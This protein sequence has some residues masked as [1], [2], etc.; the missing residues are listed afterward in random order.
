VPRC[1]QAGFSCIDDTLRHMERLQRKLGCDHR[2]VF[3]TTYLILTREFDEV[4]HEQPDFFDHR[5][6]MIYQ[7]TM[8][9]NMYFRPVAEYVARGP[10][11]EAWR[12]AFDTAGRRDA[13]AGQDMLLGINA[14][15]QR[16]FPYMLAELGIRTPDGTSRKPD[17]DRVNQI[18]ARAYEPV[19]RTIGRYCDP[20]ITTTN[21][22]GPLPTTS[23]GSRW[24][25][26]GARGRGATPSACSR[27]ARRPSERRSSSRSSRTP[28]PG[29]GR[30]P[31]AS[32]RATASG[33]TPTARAG[34]PSARR[35]PSR[36][37]PSSSTSSLG[38]R[39]PGT[40][41]ASASAPP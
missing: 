7:D 4:L 29:P 2:G 13:N 39:A 18:R 19:V 36:R 16:D 22:A 23:E 25:A 17:H 11:P 10:V 28:P 6:W 3:A 40:S 12:I 5:A 30:S 32:S 38:G 27:R 15:V 9:A 26:G 31:R 14:H 24:S 20:M 37:S 1:S 8:F 34:S 41:N 35:L 21:S 33:E